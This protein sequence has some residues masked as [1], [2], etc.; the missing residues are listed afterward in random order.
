MA[1]AGRRRPLNR[2]A[3]IRCRTWSKQRG[4]KLG[5]SSS[6]SDGN[7]EPVVKPVVHDGDV[8]S[9]HALKLGG[10]DDGGTCSPKLG[11]SGHNVSPKRAIEVE[12]GG[13]GGSCSPNMGT[14][15]CDGSQKHLHP[16]VV[17][18]NPEGACPCERPVNV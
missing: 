7:P 16:P 13:D 15:G 4:A 3:W 9:K 14:C 2:L 11:S 17:R 1:G 18:S 5:G 10:D 6:E 12:D 8:A